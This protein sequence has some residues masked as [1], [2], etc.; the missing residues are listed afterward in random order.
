M[1]YL[2]CV[3][4][5]VIGWLWNKHDW[6]PFNWPYFRRL[7]NVRPGPSEVYERLWTAEASLYTGLMPFLSPN[8]Q[9]WSAERGWLFGWMAGSLTQK[10]GDFLQILFY[11]C[12]YL[13]KK[14]EVTKCTAVRVK[15]REIFRK[16]PDSENEIIN[17]SW[18]N[19]LF[20]WKKSFCGVNSFE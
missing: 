4:V 7:L 3:G 18:F 11:C 13:Q 2:V 20:L 16:Y 19:V 15:T 1:I 14:M 6:V 17:S 9:L 10:T 8:Q 12:G 5:S